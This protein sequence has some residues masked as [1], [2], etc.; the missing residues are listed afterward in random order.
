MIEASGNPVEGAG[1]NHDATETAVRE[2]M[3]SLHSLRCVKLAEKQAALQV[4]INQ[5]QRANDHS[6][7]SEL[8]MLKF[9]L[10]KQERALALWN[11]Q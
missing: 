3:E 5:A 6:Q 8:M 11:G 7:L 9:E 4:E 1:Q 2:A 10:A